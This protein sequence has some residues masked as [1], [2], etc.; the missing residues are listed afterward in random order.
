MSAD[1]AAQKRLTG[2]RAAANL[3][4]LSLAIVEIADAVLRDLVSELAE[5]CVHA[6]AQTVPCDPTVRTLLEGAADSLPGGGSKISKA[7]HELL[8]EEATQTARCAKRSREA[9]APSFA[10]EHAQHKQQLTTC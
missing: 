1:P 10:G 4:P 2:L 3:P 9:L 5:D 8:S 7:L 6:S